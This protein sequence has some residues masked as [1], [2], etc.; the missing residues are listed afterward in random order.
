MSVDEGRLLCCFASSPTL[1][2]QW[3]SNRA[4]ALFRRRLQRTHGECR[5]HFRPDFVTAAGL[6]QRI[7]NFGSAVTRYDAALCRCPVNVR[8]RTRTTLLSYDRG[9]GLCV[10]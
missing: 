4:C 7:V 8:P 2:L 3:R 5:A 9:S 6:R 1:I 10:L